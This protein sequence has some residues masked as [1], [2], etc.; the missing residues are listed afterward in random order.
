[1]Y[2]VKKKASTGG[3][4]S[5][6]RFLEEG[7]NLQLPIYSTRLSS[8]LIKWLGDAL[9]LHMNIEVSS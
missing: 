7:I 6:C 4:E 5:F 1:M 2:L 9:H 8:A 3:L